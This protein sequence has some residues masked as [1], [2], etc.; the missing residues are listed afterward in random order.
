MKIGVKN[1]VHDTMTLAH[2]WQPELPKNLG[3]LGSIFLDEV[4]WK[5]IRRETNK[6]ND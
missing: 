5:G 6:Q 1:V 2:A 4:S 3:F